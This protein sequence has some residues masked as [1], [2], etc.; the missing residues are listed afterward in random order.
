MPKITQR[1]AFLNEIRLVGLSMTLSLA[2]NKTS[3]LW[4]QF[5]PRL[6]EIEE[7][8]N[9]DL[10]S[11]AVYP[12]AYFKA[13]HLEKSFEKYAAAEV[14]STAPIPAGMLEIRMPA[15]LY[16]VFEYQGSSN[17]SNIF[18]YIFAHWLPTSVYDLDDRPHFEVLGANYKNSDADSEEEIW[19]P[20][21]LK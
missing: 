17:D 20:V 8:S 19:I 2:D 7:R 14:S 1:T 4:Q 9:A 13:Y 15:G 18:Q 16:V 5:M 11:M 12:L 6:G 10:I 21:K 3:E